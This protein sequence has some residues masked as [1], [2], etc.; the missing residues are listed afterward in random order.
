MKELKVIDD[1]F[2]EL[3]KLLREKCAMNHKIDQENMFTFSHLLDRVKMDNE[4]VS[5]FGHILID[6]AKIALP[7]IDVNRINDILKDQFIFGI[8]N[9]RVREKCTIKL[10]KIN[11]ILRQ[12]LSM[13]E[14]INYAQMVEKSLQNDN[15]TRRSYKSITN[16][17]SDDSSSDSRKLP[18]RATENKTL[19]IAYFI[20]HQLKR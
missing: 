15:M 2:E 5:D 18:I 14:L 9:E 12:Q 8:S 13:E 1:G 16:T 6:K 19:N 7:R 3:K 11:G 17:S 20:P 4:S 10:N